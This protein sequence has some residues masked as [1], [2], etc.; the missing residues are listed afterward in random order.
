MRRLGI[1][2]VTHVLQVGLQVESIPCQVEVL[3]KGKSTARTEHLLLA[4]HVHIGIRV[5]ALGNVAV[6]LRRS[7]VERQAGQAI[8]LV[9]T[10]LP[11]AGQVHVLVTEGRK[12]A[13]AGQPDGAF[14][15]EHYRVLCMPAGGK[16]RCQQAQGKVSEVF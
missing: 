16:D 15:V 12:R 6:I 11:I 1:A 5:V 10:E 2:E 4:V 8:G 9:G 14:Q 7:E 3:L 13:V